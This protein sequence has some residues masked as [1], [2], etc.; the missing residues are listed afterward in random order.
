MRGALLASGIFMAAC[1]GGGGDSPDAGDAGNSKDVAL[2]AAPSNDANDAGGYVGLHVV[3]NAIHDGSDKTVRLL[4]VNH[5]GTEYSCVQGNGIFEGPVDDAAI[6][7]IAGW[8]A[9]VIRIPLN[10]DCWLAINGAPQNAS[11]AAYKQAISDYVDAILAHKMYAIVEL[12]WSAPGTTLATKQAPMPDQDHAIAFWS[13][14]AATFADRGNVILELFNE[15][16]PDSNQDTAAAWTCWQSGGTCPGITYQAAGM[17]SLV[18]AV[19]Q[20]GAHNL[21]LLGGV[22]YS[23]SLSQ[24]VAHAPNDPDKNI[25]AA[26]HVYNFNGCASASC[27]DKYAGVVAQSFPIVTTEIGED[28]CSGQF[29]TTLMGWLDS[30]QQNYLGWVWNTWGG[31]LVLINDYNGTPAGAYGQ[32]FKTHLASV[33]H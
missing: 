8:T 1:S 4:G 32:A 15:P 28:D 27:W 31:C 13:D 19:R 12:H 6:T 3:G 21:V 2:D 10:E 25:A 23:N 24:W 29:I 5:S 17:Q 18:D 14:V 30:K 20:A 9:N 33:P 11:G 16:F 22:E 26:W 7:T